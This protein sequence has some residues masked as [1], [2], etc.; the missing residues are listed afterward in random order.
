M[1]NNLNEINDQAAGISTNLEMIFGQMEFFGELINDMDLHSDMLP[2]LFE[3]GLIQRK[4][5]AIYYLL[6]M[7]LSEVQKAEQIISELSSHKN[8]IL[9]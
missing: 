7:Q 2:V 4:L 3:N 8:K 9:K 1:L 5:G 6:S